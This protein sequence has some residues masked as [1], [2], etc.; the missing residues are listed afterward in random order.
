MAQALRAGLRHR[1]AGGVHHHL[2]LLL[3]LRSPSQ[4]EPANTFASLASL[5]LPKAVD[6]FQRALGALR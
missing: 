1:D 5:G 2:D 6:Q 3:A 4:P